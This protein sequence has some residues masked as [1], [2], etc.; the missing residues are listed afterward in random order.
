[1]S[2]LTQS[3]ASFR[4]LLINVAP[5]TRVKLLITQVSFKMAEGERFD[6]GIPMVPL[7]YIELS[8]AGNKVIINTAFIS[9]VI[10]D[11][12]NTCRIRIGDFFVPVAG[13]LP[14]VMGLIVKSDE[15]RGVFL[16]EIDIQEFRAWK[17]SRDPKSSPIPEPSDPDSGET[18]TTITTTQGTGAPG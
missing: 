3:L 14:E 4:M 6:G 7:G 5:S 16:G 11:L 18:T 17:A 13:T 10:P 12:G 1:M 15:R 9:A 8:H 2:L